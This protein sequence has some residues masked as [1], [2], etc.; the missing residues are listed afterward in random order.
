[1]IEGKRLLQHVL[2]NIDLQNIAEFYNN[3]RLTEKAFL[4][5]KFILFFV[6]IIFERNKIHIG[7]DHHDNYKT[8]NYEPQV[9]RSVERRARKLRATPYVSTKCTSD[10]YITIHLHIRHSNT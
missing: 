5:N 1:A 3:L 6:D 4:H 10:V 7:Y 2:R 9:A 8:Q